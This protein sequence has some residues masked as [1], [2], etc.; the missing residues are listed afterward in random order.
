MTAPCVFCGIALGRIPARTVY[1]DD[2]V[3]AFLDTSPLLP[4]H[5]LVMP[6]AH[7]ETLDDLPDTLLEPLFGA[8]RRISVAVQAAMPA[9]GSFVAV[10]TRVSQS[11]PHLHVH[12]VPRRQKDGLFSPKLVWHRRPYSSE[13]EADGVATR[14]KE[15]LRGS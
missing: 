11:V 5:V 2:A 8:V 3:I 1:A 14:I 6:R 10:N 4:G 9:D 13:T 12:V 7:H 15:A